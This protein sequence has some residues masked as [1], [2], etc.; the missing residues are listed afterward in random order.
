MQAARGEDDT[1]RKQ[2][3]KKLRK[4]RTL[5]LCPA[6]L[7][8][9]WLEELEKWTN[10]NTIGTVWSITSQ[11]DSKRRIP[12][13]DEWYSDG[14]G[15]ILLM[16]YELFRQWALN[17]KTDKRGPRFSEEEH[18]GIIKKLLDGPSL[19]VA[20]EAHKLKNDK[21]AITR[22]AKMLR[23]KSR[24]ALTGSPLSN[25][26]NEYFAMVDWIAPG[27]LGEPVEFRA[28]YVE[29][30]EEGLYVGS[31]HAERR[32]ARIKLG[33]LTR[34]L[35]PKIHRK[36]IEALKKDLKPKTEFVLNVPLAP[37]QMEAYKAFVK[38]A[39]SGI[40][41]NASN[42]RFW[43][44]MGCLQLLCSHPTLFAE[45]VDK[46]KAKSKNKGKN[47]RARSPLKRVQQELLD[48]V[49][50]MKCHFPFV[51]NVHRQARAQKWATEIK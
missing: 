3:P 5:I 46:G 11:V 40:N 16:G 13:L 24:I 23:S 17:A 34:F 32:T 26:L 43:G 7:I 29:P 51:T 38:I 15:G 39:N 36:E 33:A 2:I 10:P 31:S 50:Y 37:L 19:I 21:S 49:C 48:E 41:A 45:H 18:K 25:N 20:D 22:A 27:Y 6:G 12:V 14:R 42:A 1:I 8:K 9:N 28:N 4:M 35:E 30:I 47:N 44:L